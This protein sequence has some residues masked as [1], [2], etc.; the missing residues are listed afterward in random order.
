[1]TG[2]KPRRLKA[3][4]A[5]GPVQQ[6]RTVQRDLVVVGASAGGVDSLQQLV[7][8]LP[9]EFPAA[10][11]IVLHVPARGTS[12]MPQI[13]SRRGPLPAEFARDDTPLERGQIYVAPADHHLLV[14]D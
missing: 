9:A 14:R 3:I 6:S 4:E 13:L 10:I 8:G 2:D 1:M 5:A 7:A 11:M 12:V